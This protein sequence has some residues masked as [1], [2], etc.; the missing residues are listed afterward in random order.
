MSSHS[1]LYQHLRLDST[2]VLPLSMDPLLPLPQLLLCR[3][4]SWVTSQFSPYHV[5]HISSSVPV[6]TPSITISGGAVAVII[7]PILATSVSVITIVALVLKYR[8]RDQS[9]KRD[10]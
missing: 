7:V 2:S 5:E 10:G 4:S 6:P 3:V 9:I 1:V 8:H